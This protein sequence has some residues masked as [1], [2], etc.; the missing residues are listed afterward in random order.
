MVAGDGTL[1]YVS[2]G[3]ATAAA[4]LRTL[5]LV[6]RQG[7][8][9]PILAPPRAY[10]YPRLSPDGTRIAVAAND[11][12]NDIWVWARGGTELIPFTFNPGSDTFPVWTP[13]S[14][15]LIFSSDREGA[16]DLFWQAA[17]GTGPV[18][19]LTNSPT[20]K[21]PTAVAPSPG[22]SQVIFIETGSNKTG[23]DV[24]QV[25]LDGTHRVTPL[26]QTASTERN[27]VVSADGRWLAY[28]ASGT[29]GQLQIYVRPYPDVNGGYRQVSTGGGTRPA[30]ARSGS[31]QELFFVSTDDE[32]M[33]VRV[34]QGATWVPTAPTKVLGP[35]YYYGAN[36]NA[37]RTYDVSPDGQTILMIKEGGGT[38][39]TA[40]PAQIVVVQH[41]VEE[42]KRLVPTK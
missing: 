12:E 23:L 5:V 35:K 8:E 30:W 27:G 34:G 42:L 25:E 11:Q 41:W 29:S 7:R 19:R 16:Q 39:Q 15:R 33:S 9:T 13:D 3:G 31:G 40:A 6:D 22:G 28:E 24:M 4:A 1:V 32:L 17:N 20:A 38:D 37:G 26:V 36:G 21:Y 14:R 10:T 2:G 18:Q